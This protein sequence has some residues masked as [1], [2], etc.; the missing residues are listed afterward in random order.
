MPNKILVSGVCC[1]LLWASTCRGDV[2]QIRALFQSIL[3]N[4]DESQLPSSKDTG[5]QIS[6]V[7]T[8][9]PSEI[10]EIL[11]LGQAC[12]HSPIKTVRAYG[13]Y[14]IV[15][16]ATRADGSQLIERYL[17]DISSFLGDP[18]L[19]FRREAVFILG[20]SNPRPLPGGIQ[21]L[22]AHL[23]DKDNT[24]WETG[25]I[26]GALLQFSPS[27]SGT[28]RGVLSVVQERADPKLTIAVIQDLGLAHVVT[29]EALKFIR[30][31][32]ASTDP[33]IRR[34]TVDALAQMPG[35]VKSGFAAELQIIV[36][37]SSEVPETR[38]RARE[39]MIQRR[40]RPNR[41][42]VARMRRLAVE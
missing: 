12:L 42:S 37:N 36:G 14:L 41:E 2:A 7:A 33:N 15:A 16:I 31:S 35:E 27:D 10:E 5:R 11:L 29:E 38:S 24:S 18:D 6:V 17:D 1:F 32:L 28:V 40:P 9:V 3:A 25:M 20:S 19:A 22:A 13:L 23:R 26:A 21:R 8:L 34:A 4:Q 30:S 39:V